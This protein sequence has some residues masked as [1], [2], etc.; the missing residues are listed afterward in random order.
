MLSSH[1]G[2]QL[3]WRLASKLG[4]AV[5]AGRHAPGD[6]LPKES[7]LSASES[8]G[9]SCVREA[10]KILASKGL[11]DTRPRLGTRVQPVQRW[12]LYDRDVQAWMAAA[13]PRGQLLKELLQVRLMCEPHAAALAAAHRNDA[14]L[15]K[16]RA[17]YERMQSAAAGEDDPYA[18]DL[19]FHTALL[20]ASGNRFVAGLAPL[21][22]TAL[23]ASFRA[24]NAARGDAVGD[25]ALHAA[26]LQAIVRGKP[27]AARRAS[28]KLLADVAAVC[29]RMNDESRI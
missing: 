10:V 28:L 14:H 11:V 13:S 22:S 12:N 8:V 15:E 9:R 29:E 2:T 5:V 1:S 26:V 16:L 25:L 21:L 18:A 24:T 23:L 3:S 27:E 6:Q 20:E 7:S 19:A 4:Q 17:A